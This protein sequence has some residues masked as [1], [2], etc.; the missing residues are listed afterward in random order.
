[1]ENDDWQ[2]TDGVIPWKLFFHL[3]GELGRLWAL[4][5]LNDVEAA[6]LARSLAYGDDRAARRSLEDLTD[7]AFPGV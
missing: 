3:H 7:T 5:R 4:D 2:T 6:A 1:M